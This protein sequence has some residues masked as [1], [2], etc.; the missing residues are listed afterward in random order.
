M[1]ISIASIVDIMKGNMGDATTDHT[2]LP[3]WC[4]VS[5]SGS[6][7]PVV[8]SRMIDGYRPMPWAVEWTDT[9]LVKANAMIDVDEKQS[10]CM[11]TGSMFGWT[12]PGADPTW[13]P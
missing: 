8:V 2:G 13:R 12:V 5:M 10:Q 6:G 3:A 9:Q 7:E 11:L 4:F 1:M